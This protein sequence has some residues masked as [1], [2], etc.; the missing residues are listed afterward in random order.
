MVRYSYLAIVFLFFSC[1][2]TNN[3]EQEHLDTM[4]T[5]LPDVQIQ[6]EINTYALKDTVVKFLW[7]ENKY[8]EQLDDT[9]NSIFINEGYC[10]TITDPEKAALGYVAT[11]IGN[12]CQWDGEA[13]DDMSNLKCAVIT[14]LDLGYQCSDKH[15]IF[16]RKWFSQDSTVLETLKSCPK[17]PFTASSQT[18]FGEITLKTKGDTIS[19][20]YS[21]SGMNMRMGESWDWTETDYFLLAGD[22]LKLIKKDKSEVQRT[23]FDTGEE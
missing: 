9:V 18:T 17:V 4:A 12:E 8:D 23:H 6:A 14:A 2:Q 22:N 21:A 13:D 7:R 1:G 15:L 5:T 16:L 19:V 3:S 11:F 10:Q 20:S